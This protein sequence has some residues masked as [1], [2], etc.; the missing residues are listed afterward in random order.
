MTSELDQDSVYAKSI[1]IELGNMA[2]NNLG[3]ECLTNLQT[4]S[5]ACFPSLIRDECSALSAVAFGASV[6]TPFLAANP[7]AAFGSFAVSY[8]ARKLERGHCFPQ[9]LSSFQHH[10]NNTE[11][12]AIKTLANGGLR[13]LNEAQITARKLGVD[14]DKLL[15]AERGMGTIARGLVAKPHL[16]GINHVLDQVRKVVLEVIPSQKPITTIASALAV[17]KAVANT[18][19]KTISLGAS[20]QEQ[21]EIN[22]KYEA[23][24]ASLTPGQVKAKANSNG[25]FSKFW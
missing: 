18:M 21:F 22:K 25:F 9:V 14:C 4:N 23:M 8:I 13:L 10:S 1:G 12:L 16:D 3:L 11:T 24:Q 7:F 20:L 6:A 5:T 15:N 17:V 2:Y 19:L